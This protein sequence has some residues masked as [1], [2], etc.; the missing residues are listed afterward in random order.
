MLNNSGEFEEQRKIQA[1]KW[2]WSQ[3][4]EGL[5]KNFNSNP[6]I[7]VKVSEFEKAVIAGK[8]LPTLA[9]KELLNEWN[10]KK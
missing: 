6:I 10:L 9:A 1:S 2:M 4:K 8:M 3:V 5:L 7:Q